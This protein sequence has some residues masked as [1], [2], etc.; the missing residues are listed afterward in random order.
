MEPWIRAVLDAEADDFVPTAAPD[1]FNDGKIVLEFW[2]GSSRTI[3][4]GPELPE[5]PGVEN[6]DA[7]RSA[8]ISGSPYVYALSSWT[9]TRLFRDA[10]YFSVAP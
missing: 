5:T 8:A 10:A 1:A 3:R 4:L 9:V 7:R 6:A 2:D